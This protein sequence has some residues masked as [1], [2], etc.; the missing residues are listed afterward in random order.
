MS[1]TA[2]LWPFIALA[3]LVLIAML[4]AGLQGRPTPN[5]AGITPAPAPTFTVSQPPSSGFPVADD[6]EPNPFFQVLANVVLLGLL[7]LLAVAA[8]AL[9]VIA[10]RALARAWRARP[11]R[12][13]DG[14]GV[15]AVREGGAA[16]G[17]DEHI[18]TRSVQRGIAAAL[19]DVDERPRPADAIVA[20]WLGLEQ[21]AADAGA[22]RGASETPGEF[23]LR[24]ITRRE[25]LS[26]D[27]RTLLGL[28]QRVRFGD[29]DADETDRAAA[30]RA[31]RRIEEGWR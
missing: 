15:G 19:H 20:A 18:D 3:G 22:A 21:S 23:A 27:A 1:R 17:A 28:Y 16:I 13:T 6:V 11:L 31:L 10:I 25:G 9:L 24:I 29:H 14:D 30:R 4:A 2:R 5:G 8:L 7:V 26:V 12:R